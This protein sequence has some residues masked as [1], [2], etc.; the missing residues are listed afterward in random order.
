MQ[1][2]DLPQRG[3]TLE[4]TVS[5]GVLV[6]KLEGTRASDDGEAIHDAM[7]AWSRIAEL[8]EIHRADRVLVEV[9]LIGESSSIRAHGVATSLAQIKL[10][11][12]IRIAIVN[13]DERSRQHTAFAV[14][15][16]NSRGWTAEVFEAEADAQAW[17]RRSS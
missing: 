6:V 7:G 2:A 14:R 15:L 17:L 3:R 12:D 16:A 8:C 1:S 13:R 4:S 11:R 5:D 10:R 9:N